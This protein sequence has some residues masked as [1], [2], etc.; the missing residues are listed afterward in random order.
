MKSKTTVFLI[1]AL[2]ACVAYVVMWRGNFF[3]PPSGKPIPENTGPILGDAPVEPV[4]LTLRSQAGQQIKFRSSPSGWQI[5]EPIEASAVD[6]KIQ[7]LIKALASIVCTDRY[8]PTDS[9]APGGAVTGL[10]S[11]RWTVTLTDKSQKTRSLEIGLHVPLSGNTRTYARLA[12]DTQ[13]CVIQDDLTGR[14][15]RPVSYYR[16]PGVLKIAPESIMSVL[17]SGSETYSLYRKA[18]DQWAIKSETGD[19]G[20]FPTDKRETQAFLNRFAQID[21]HE[22]VDDNLSDLAPYGLAGGSERLKVTVTF[23]T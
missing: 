16:S 7:T 14:L 10:Q 5:V 13:I 4:E 8:Q 21:A 15:S 1:V 11:P 20:E 18:A 19:T 17:V 2:M 23:M 9:D 3:L 6:H 12:G 22:F